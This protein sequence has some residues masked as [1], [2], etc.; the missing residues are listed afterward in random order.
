[1]INVLKTKTIAH[2]ILLEVIKN[3][4]TRSFGLNPRKGGSPP[5][6][7]IVIKTIILSIGLKL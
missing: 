7:S 4:I 2:S 5:N 3:V 1:M 6:D